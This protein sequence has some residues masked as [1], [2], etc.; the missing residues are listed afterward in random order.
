MFGGEKAEYV[1]VVSRQPLSVLVELAPV[2]KP[3][4]L[5]VRDD[6]LV[7]ECPL[8]LDRQHVRHGEIQPVGV[9]RGV[10]NDRLGLMRVERRLRSGLDLHDAA[11]ICLVR[12]RE[13]AW[14]VE[15]Q[16]LSVGVVR[17]RLDLELHSLELGGG[18]L[19]QHD[20]KVAVDVAAA[21]IL[22]LVELAPALVRSHRAEFVVGRERIARQVVTKYGDVDVFRESL[23]ERG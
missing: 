2:L 6:D 5:S 20:L 13:C 10:R 17:I 23:D 18:V 14:I 8:R 1:V 19:R 7:P 9:G 16:G 12:I 21:S 4:T 3:V 22:D 15:E 11:D